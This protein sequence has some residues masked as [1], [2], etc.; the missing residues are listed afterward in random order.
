M[1]SFC[2]P[3]PASYSVREAS[4]RTADGKGEILF[5]ASS[6]RIHDGMLLCVTPHDSETWQGVFP[7]GETSFSCISTCPLP[8]QMLVISHG[9][10][11]LVDVFHPNASATFVS[12]FAAGIYA[13]SKPDIL[14]FFTMNEICATDGR[15][16]LWSF[17][18]G[19]DGFRNFDFGE[20]RVSFEAFLPEFSSYRRFTL[21]ADTGQ[22]C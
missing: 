9:N 8:S 10:A 17:Q 14:L 6:G 1:S 21:T 2:T 5:P 3:Y 11:F 22:Q 19:A 15:S 20:G 13:L 7:F 4:E 12:A 16:L 18:E